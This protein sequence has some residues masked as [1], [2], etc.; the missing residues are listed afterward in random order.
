MG[1]TYCFLIFHISVT[2]LWFKQGEV[3]IRSPWSDQLCVF[4]VMI[5]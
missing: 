2:T 1:H 5:L 4:H 3:E